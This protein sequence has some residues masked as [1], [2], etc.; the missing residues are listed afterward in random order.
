MSYWAEPGAQTVDTIVKFDHD[1]D[2]V[3]LENKVFKALGTVTADK[4]YAKAGA[5]SATAKSDHI[6]YNKTT[7]DLYYD[8][9]GKGGVGAILFANLANHAKLDHGDFLIVWTQR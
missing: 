7:G 2:K 4:F 1:K 6:I 5:T 3:A 8:K 9:D